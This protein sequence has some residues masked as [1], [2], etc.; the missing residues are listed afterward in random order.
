MR[1]PQ[2]GP[3][4]IKQLLPHRHPV[5]LIDRILDMAP[6]EWLTALKA[7]TCDEPWYGGLPD[8][9][10][11]AAYSYPAAL[12]LESW[13]QSAAAL[14]AVGESHRETPAA[15]VL[16]FAGMSRVRFTGTVR[17]GD[18]VVHQARVTRAFEDTVAFEGES[19]VNGATVLEVGQVLIA[20][21][22]AAD[23][24]GAVASAG[25]RSRA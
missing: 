23:P 25:E 11:D 20:R 9:A 2:I 24:A 7:V 22:P 5:L 18:A 6:G 1:S 19:R 4:G 21:R 10:D 15:G 8:D 3:V 13:C 14:M 16:L 12:L 17:P